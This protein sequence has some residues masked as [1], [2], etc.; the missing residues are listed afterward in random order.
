MCA[1]GV[2]KRGWDPVYRIHPST[3]AQRLLARKACCGKNYKK[4]S[5]LVFIRS[6]SELQ[7][8][9]LMLAVPAGHDDIVLCT[10]QYSSTEHVFPRCGV[11]SIAW[12]VS[13]FTW[14]RAFGCLLDELR[15]ITPCASLANNSQAVGPLAALFAYFVL[16][17]T[18][19]CR[20]TA[21]VCG[22]A[23]CLM[24]NRAG[25]TCAYSQ[26]TRYTCRNW[27]RQQQ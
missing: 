24:N 26:R 16:Q 25:I 18:Q 12:E 9:L 21:Y 8:K 19:H 7:Y 27:A 4:K 2:V 22:T 13:V 20:A 11:V 15:C 1:R 6:Y 3:A 17:Y 5:P 14:G 23:V 10:A